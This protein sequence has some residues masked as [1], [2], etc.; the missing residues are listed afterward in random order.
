MVEN[1][2]IA[3]VIGSDINQLLR[4]IWSALTDAV[5]PRRRRAGMEIFMM[6]VK[7]RKKIKK[8]R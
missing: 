3:I 8:R 1:S 2:S 4:R 7:P 6:M 5:A